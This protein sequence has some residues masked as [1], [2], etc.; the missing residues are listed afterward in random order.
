M[1]L[2]GK[3]VPSPMFD[4]FWGIRWTFLDPIFAPSRAKNSI[5]VSLDRE[6]IPTSMFSKIL[7]SKLDSIFSKYNYSFRHKGTC[8]KVGFQTHSKWGKLDL[9]RFIYPKCFLYYFIVS[10]FCQTNYAALSFLTFFVTQV[11]SLLGN[12][13]S[14]RVKVWAPN[15]DF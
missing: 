4:N 2:L 12:F 8:F 6:V 15:F 3:N 7:K 9:L 11:S 13:S 10:W 14:V 1:E 5:F